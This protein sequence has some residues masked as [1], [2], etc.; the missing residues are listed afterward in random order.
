MRDPK[1][2]PDHRVGAG[3]GGVVFSPELQSEAVLGLDHVIAGGVELMGGW[4]VGVGVGGWF[5]LGLAWFGL[6]RDGM[7]V[8]G[9]IRG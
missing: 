6:V 2:V 1:R 5:G 8:G 3:E 7:G 9:L 4:G